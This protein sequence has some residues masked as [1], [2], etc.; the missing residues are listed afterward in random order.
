GL[1]NSF[2][3]S[4]NNTIALSKAKDTIVHF[5]INHHQ[6]LE[7]IN[8][9]FSAIPLADDIK[10]QETAIRKELNAHYKNRDDIRS[11]AFSIFLAYKHAELLLNNPNEEWKNFAGLQKLQSNW[12]SEEYFDG[13]L[14]V[15]HAF[16]TTFPKSPK[17]EKLSKDIESTFSLWN[18]RNS[19]QKVYETNI[20]SFP[21]LTNASDQHF[22]LLGIIEHLERRYKFNP[23]HKEELVDWCLKDVEIYE[24]FLK[25]FHE[26]ELFTI[27]DQ[28]KFSEN[29]SLKEKKLS[30]ITFDHVKRLKN[31]MVPRLNS[32]DVL[33]VIYD[34][35]QNLEKLKWIRGI[36][37]HIGY[38]D[39]QSM[40]EQE[41]VPVPELDI[42][43]ITRTIEVAQSGQKGKLAFLNSSQEPCSTEDVFQD[44]EKNNGWNVMRAE[45]SFWQSMF[46][47]SF[48]DE[49]FDGMGRPVSGQ[50]I[51]H[52]LFRGDDFY[53]NRQA[54]INSKYE[55]LR[56]GN[57]C[58]FINQQLDKTNGS[59]T[60]LLFNG[61]Q[62]MASY[63]KSDIVQRFLNQIDP[64][65]FAKIV[66]RIAQNPNENRAGV[67]D[68]VIWNGKELRMSEIKKVR[69]TVRDS[70]RVW[71]TWM[72][73]EGIPVEIVRVKGQ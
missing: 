3:P 42:L 65:V 63:S 24:G 15:M 36:G 34:K 27:D 12:K 13:L 28:I 53:L 31:Y 29:S 23:Q 50:D 5:L 43:Q 68:F 22:C 66:Y 32:Y 56:Q 55:I 59:W 14:T 17:T 47:L 73:S 57:L 45:V 10:K 39:N 26:H 9:Q 48:W 19:S 62:D 30:K 51:P 1:K 35:E 25:E 71:L 60:R 58:D 41:I 54:D 64:E 49:I 52:D 8:A 37:E 44:H 72:V 7:E 38:A 67:P 46:C 6:T 40:S 11:K 21:S 61:D 33:E 2:Q 16:K 70:Q 4:D 18:S 20:K 69:E